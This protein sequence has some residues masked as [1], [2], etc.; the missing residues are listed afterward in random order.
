MNLSQV[1]KMTRIEKMKLSRNEKFSF[2]MCTD[3]FNNNCY[4]YERE[5]F[6]GF[7]SR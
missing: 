1:I 2:N 4:V 3:F 5:Y 7:S 6:K